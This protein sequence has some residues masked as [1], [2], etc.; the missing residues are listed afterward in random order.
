VLLAER[1]LKDDDIASLLD[2]AADKPKPPP[3]VR[4]PK[5]V[6]Q[7]VTDGL[8]RRLKDLNLGEPERAQLTDTLG[9]FVDDLAQQRAKE[10]KLEAETLR[11]EVSTRTALLDNLPWGVILWNKEGQA[12]YLNA[13]GQ[14]LLKTEAGPDLR[15][16]VKALLN[17]W[18]FPLKELPDFPPEAQLTEAEI[19]LLVLAFRVVRD[20]TGGIQALI[21]MPE[22]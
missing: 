22:R 12:A 4:K 2:A 14:S 6:A 16:P 13:A 18:A 11:A 17:T 19:R 5:P 10:F 7:L 8:Q 3:R 21:L 9:T 1:G 15:E 20:S